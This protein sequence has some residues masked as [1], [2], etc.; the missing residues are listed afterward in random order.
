MTQLHLPSTTATDHTLSNSVPPPV[1]P[2]R[3]PE[4]S[5]S[6]T[7]LDASLEA[8]QHLDWHRQQQ[9]QQQHMDYQSGYSGTAPTPL[10]LQQSYPRQHPH[11]ADAARVPPQP[12]TFSTHPPQPA[13]PPRQP[14]TR[15]A[16]Y[17]LPQPPVHYQPQPQQ[18]AYAAPAPVVVDPQAAALA[19]H[20]AELVAYYWHYAQH[21]LLA[22]VNEGNE[23]QKRARDE[24]VGWAR[25][26]GIQ[27]VDPADMGMVP[28]IVGQG[29]TVGGAGVAQQENPLP[30]AQRPLPQPPVTHSHSALSQPSGVDQATGLPCSN[31]HLPLAEPSQRPLPTPSGPPTT[32]RP[33]P[34]PSAVASVPSAAPPTRPPLPSTPSQLMRST[35]LASA[36]SAPPPQ[37]SLNRSSSVVVTPTVCPLSA[38]GGKRPLPMPPGGGGAATAPSVAVLSDRMAQLALA[39]AVST[40]TVPVVNVPGVEE[41]AAAPTVPSFSFPDDNENGVPYFAVTD[42]SSPAPPTFSFGSDDD[43]QS[44]H[45]SL[46]SISFGSVA[47]PAPPPKHRLH[48]R[49]DPSHPSHYLYHPTS[50]PLSQ[51]S[52]AAE[53]GTLVCISC[54]T[55]IYGRALRAMGHEWHPECFVCQEEGCGVALEFV[56]FDGRVGGESGE[57][58]EVEVWCMVHFEEVSTAVF[59]LLPG[60]RS[61]DS[62]L[63]SHAQ[64]MTHPRRR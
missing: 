42:D 21:G 5:S 49:H 2:P 19:A 31:G 53:A 64:C 52:S 33:L 9:Q 44:S 25:S 14:P 43:D 59:T 38:T 1:P 39:H 40:S 24:A 37:V 8:V 18:P 17:P 10:D 51:R 12:Q 46:P 23:W 11:P 48:P 7:T 55:P 28:V 3:R 32:S 34:T 35:S 30:S 6:S 62:F 47:A 27:V 63:P 56:Q 22:P 36:P 60:C 13:L 61:A 45:A 58:N 29:A 50:S 16:T 54:A 41:P 4:S 26:Q 20:H 15:S 57:G